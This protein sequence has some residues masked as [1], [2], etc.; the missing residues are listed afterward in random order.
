MKIYRRATVVNNSSPT[1]DTNYL[2]NME[3]TLA[4]GYTASGRLYFADR[5]S[6]DIMWEQLGYSKFASLTTTTV[7]LKTFIETAIA[8]ADL[9][10]DLLVLEANYT[11]ARKHY[12]A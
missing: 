5:N 7:L 12:Y 10:A 4:Q 2:S 9:E 8:N 3:D 11:N 6:L 1:A